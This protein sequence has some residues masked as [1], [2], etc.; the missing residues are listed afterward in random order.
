LLPVRR[1]PKPGDTTWMLIATG[2]GGSLAGGT[3]IHISAGVSGLV[4]AF[5]LGKRED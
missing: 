4:V 2:L 1:L 3:V 5:T